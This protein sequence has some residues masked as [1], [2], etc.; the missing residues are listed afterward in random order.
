MKRF[1]K[2]LSTTLLLSGSL[3]LITSCSNTDKPSNSENSTTESE[4]PSNSSS[5][6]STSESTT[7]GGSGSSTT[8]TNPTPT[9]TPTTPEEVKTE[10]E[11]TISYPNNDNFVVKVEEGKVVSLNKY[12]KEI[13]GYTFVGFFSDSA[14]ETQI[15]TYTV[16]K[17]S[18]IYAKYS[19]NS[20]TPTPTPEHTHTYSTEYSHDS[21][22]HWKECSE[23]DS[24][25]EEAEHTFVNEAIDEYKYSD[26]TYTSKA[27]YYSHCSVCGAKGALFENGDILHNYYTLNILSNYDSVEISEF[28]YR[29]D[30]V[31]NADALLNKIKELD[32]VKNVYEVIGLYSD[33]NFENS[34]EGHI[35]TANETV[36]VKLEKINKTI[37][38]KTVGLD[39]EETFNVIKKKNETLTTS[40]LALTIEDTQVLGYYLDEE[41]NEE[42]SEMIVDSDLVVYAK[43]EKAL[44]LVENEVETKVST[45]YENNQYTANDAF[46]VKLSLYF[47]KNIKTL[48]VTF[49]DTNNKTY[50]AVVSV[51]GN[52]ATATYAFS[53]DEINDSNNTIT[54]S[55]YSITADTIEFNIDD[56]ETSFT[57]DDKELTTIQLSSTNVYDDYSAYIYTKAKS[58]SIWLSEYNTKWNKSVNYLPCEASYN[59]EAN[60]LVN[61]NMDGLEVLYADFTLTEDIKIYSRVAYIHSIF[62]IKNYCGNLDLNGHTIEL[63]FDGY[64][65]DGLFT[66]NYGRIYNGTVIINGVRD[67][68]TGSA[69][70]NT[71]KNNYAVMK[72]NYGYIHNITFHINNFGFDFS[73]NHNINYVIEDNEYFGLVENCV[74]HFDMTYNG[75]KLQRIKNPLVGSGSGVFGTVKT[76]TI[77]DKSAKY[78]A[79]QELSNLSVY[80]DSYTTSEELQ[81]TGLVSLTCDTTTNV[82]LARPIAGFGELYT[83]KT[84]TTSSTVSGYIYTDEGLSNNGIYY[85]G[86]YY[87]DGE[88]YHK[89]NNAVFNEKT[90]F[91][92]IYKPTQIYKQL[93]VDLEK[94]KEEYNSRGY[95]N[96][97]TLNNM[98]E[99]NN[100]Y[101]LTWCEDINGTHADRAEGTTDCGVTHRY[102]K[103]YYCEYG[104][105]TPEFGFLACDTTWTLSKTNNLWGWYN[106]VSKDELS[107]QTYEDYQVGENPSDDTSV[108]LY[109]EQRRVGVAL[110][111]SKIDVAFVNNGKNINIDYTNVAEKGYKNENN[112]WTTTTLNGNFIQMAYNRTTGKAWWDYYSND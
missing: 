68:S 55:K 73:K 8:E 17:N 12:A 9:P 81:E 5:G 85:G 28:T 111:G 78:N 88:N 84:E 110:T 45:Y 112:V 7:T 10:Y 32:G 77:Y 26:A 79:T 102:A 31:L 101:M 82:T 50:D 72:N 97:C 38:I 91:G 87:F 27:L 83:H 46:Q 37:T 39:T 74:F 20:I 65:G 107:S 109:S 62:A 43:V 18:T 51:N 13:E 61:I 94:S 48:N 96:D 47:N 35:L 93:T 92:S 63:N 1:R 56:N 34:I 106:I 103:S 90:N 70:F 67:A 21:T 23:H 75:T 98:D 33:A 19:E 16:N 25:I 71:L 41:L 86:N 89:Y 40:D 6:S 2:I 49:I 52:S 4:K 36:Y 30:E 105:L 44:K 95:S 59:R 22:K 60:T 80:I 104:Y 64:A 29:D 69:E 11:L 54:V 58:D 15:F 14:Y 3:A 99:I 57:L 24:K 42:F 66:N 76:G 100:S 53:V 108:Y